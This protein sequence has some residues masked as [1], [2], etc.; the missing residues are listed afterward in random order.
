[1]AFGTGTAA[2]P[3]SPGQS[4]PTDFSDKKM[5]FPISTHPSPCS[6]RESALRRLQSAVLLDQW[7]Q[8]GQFGHKDQ[9]YVVKN[10]N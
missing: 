4:L 7:V 2:P 9:H 6:P 3:P 1:M 10:L 5:L 8:K